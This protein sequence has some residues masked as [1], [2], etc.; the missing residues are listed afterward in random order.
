ME[1]LKKGGITD[2]PGIKV[3]HA[4]E[5]VALTGCTVV[6]CEDGAVGGVEVCGMA[7]GTREIDALGLL[8]LVPQVHGILLAGGSAFGLDA[9]SGVMRY[10]E[11]RG[12]GFDVTVTRVPIVPAAVVFDLHLGDYRVR[13]DREMGYAACQGA[14]DGVVEEGSVGVGTGCTVGKL[15]GL[16]R[17]MKGGV[18]TTS[19]LTPRG[20]IVGTL[21]A[22]NAFGDVVDEQ[23]KPVAGLRASREGWE[24]LD[25]ARLLCRGEQP[26]GFMLQHTTL[27]VVA[28]DVTLSKIEARTVAHMARSGLARALSPAMTR[29]D[30]DVIFVLSLGQK[31]EDVN[32]VGCL[33]QELLRQAVVRGVTSAEGLGGIPSYR[34]RPAG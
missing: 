12:K 19:G 16:E 23:G 28:T 7:S 25:S 14:S 10:L 6:L 1:Q 24:L 34:D 17:A 8:H 15:L 21:A 32:T 26:R 3:G 27:G 18:G 33:A 30:G 20:G 5:A 4:T 11:E 29:F 13:P 9:A 31:A 22:V 2:V